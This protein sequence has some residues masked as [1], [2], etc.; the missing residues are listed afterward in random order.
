MTN[1]GAVSS[2]PVPP[3]V[4]VGVFALVTIAGVVM[5]FVTTSDD[6]T[7]EPVEEEPEEADEA[8]FARA[9]GR[10]ADRI[11]EANVAVDNAVYQAWVDMTGLLD[12]SNP[13]T[14]APL[15]FADRAI[16][17]G[18]D[19]DDVYELTELFNEVRYGGMDPENREERA[20][21]I[22]R[23]IEETY[24]ETGEGGGE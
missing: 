10:A 8:A 14:T 9:A 17:V 7:F 20:V 18:L 16:A 21:E 24:R 5:L 11:E 15:D 6:E 13:K 1:D 4:L 19:E 22:L 12:I 3:S 23:H 2:V